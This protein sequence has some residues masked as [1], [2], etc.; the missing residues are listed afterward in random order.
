MGKERITMER[1]RQTIRGIDGDAWE[2]LVEVRESS[3]TQTGAPVSDAL[4]FWY[5]NLPTAEE[6]AVPMALER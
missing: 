2:M 5:D 1:K 4:R 3:R 6:I